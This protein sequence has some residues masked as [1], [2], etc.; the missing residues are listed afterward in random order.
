[1]RFFIATCLSASVALA[2][3]GGG[4]NA[5]EPAV[6][7]AAEPTVSVVNNEGSVT[8]MGNNQVGQMLTAVVTDLDGANGT[9]SYQWFA[10]G[11]AV[12][13]ASAE[14]YDL[15]GADLNTDIRVQA[16][17]TDDSG[18]IESPLSDSNGPV[19]AASGLDPSV[20]PGQNFDLLGWYLSTPEENPSGLSTRI[21][22]V[23]L[24]GGYEHPD[25]FWTSDDGGMV[26]RVT[27]EGARTSSNTSY[28]RTELREMLRRGDTSIST[29]SSDGTPTRNNWVFSSAPASA[30]QAA[31][32]VDGQLKATL[33]V[34]AVTTSG[35]S[36]RVGRVI[37]GQIHAKDDEPIRLYYRKLP[38]N[39][40]G[41]IYAAHEINGG[42]DI[43]Y[44]MIGSRSNSLSD[45]ANGIALDELWSY[46]ILAQGNQLQVTI[47]SGDLYGAIIGTANIDMSASGYDIA[48]EFMYF[49]AGAYNQNNTSDGGL[50]DDFSQVTF[51][52][53]EASHN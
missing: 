26:F 18:F 19:F 21:A 45:P 8:S 30:Q 50:A 15:T 35:S 49:K 4:S 36:G 39:Q 23:D 20:P 47:R 48:Q 25:Y 52:Q 5:A 14:T 29:R 32:A 24:A 22:E 42:D 28:P 53:L 31:G 34:N 2:G 46:E 40:R 17:Y 7:V 43:Y 12:A 44:E 51:Y 38:Q 10:D 11:V 1:M 3:C 33:A 37:V 27:N 13:G 16:S 41:A 9:I 6:A